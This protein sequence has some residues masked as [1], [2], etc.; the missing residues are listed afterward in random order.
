[1]ERH[2]ASPQLAMAHAGTFAALPD[3]SVPCAFCP[4]VPHRTWPSIGLTWEIKSKRPARSRTGQVI[5]SSP[6]ARPGRSF[7]DQPRPRP[8]TSAS[9]PH[10]PARFGLR[11]KEVQ[12][13]QW[14][15]EDDS[16]NSSIESPHRRRKS[17]ILNPYYSTFPLRQTQQNEL[18][19]PQ[20]ERKLETLSRCAHDPYWPH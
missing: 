11:G 15:G 9:Q 14:F 2:P 6:L 7:S 3:R 10:P 18:D 17:I 19:G 12:R 20:P 4:P 8:T 5:K 1:M 13:V 16:S